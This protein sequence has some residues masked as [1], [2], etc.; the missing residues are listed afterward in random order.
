MDL[1]YEKNVGPTQIIE[2]LT[3][4]VT[5]IFDVFLLLHFYNFNNRVTV[6]YNVTLIF[7]V[8]L[9]LHHYNFNNRVTVYISLFLFFP[10]SGVR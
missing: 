6:Y 9:L 3:V 7:G 5:L 2:H 8:F 10:L 1:R 4:Y